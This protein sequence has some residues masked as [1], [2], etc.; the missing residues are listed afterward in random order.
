MPWTIATTEE[1]ERRLEGL[2]RACMEVAREHRKRKE[3]IQRMLHWQL[4]TKS[5][6]D[7]MKSNWLSLVP[8]LKH[9]LSSELQRPSIE[10]SP[11][12]LNCHSCHYLPSTQLLSTLNKN[13]CADSTITNHQLLCFA[14]KLWVLD[15]YSSALQ[16]AF[17]HLRNAARTHC[18]PSL[19]AAVAH[20]FVQ[21]LC[22]LLFRLLKCSSLCCLLTST[23]KWLQRDR[24]KCRAFALAPDKEASGN[25]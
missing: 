3:T 17:S 14:T 25:S 6:R 16:P 20:T 13:G 4:P 9:A 11:R 18:P 10:R 8:Q 1:E 24:S 23:I 2:I 15:V 12:V 7:N 19:P 5:K 21:P 22:L